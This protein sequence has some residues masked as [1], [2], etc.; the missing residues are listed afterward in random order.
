MMVMD[1][2]NDDDDKECSNAS[3]MVCDKGG[4]HNR[5]EGK[6][7]RING[8]YACTLATATT[9][10]VM[11]RRS[12]NRQRRCKEMQRDNQ[13]AQTERRG[14]GW[15]CATPV[16][17]K[18]DTRRRHAKTGNA[19]T[20]WHTRGKWE[21]RHQQTTGNGASIDQG[22]AFRGGGRV[23][24]MRGG[25]INV[26]TSRQRRDDHGGGK[27]DKEWESFKGLREADRA[28]RNMVADDIIGALGMENKMI[29]VTI[30][31]GAV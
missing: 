22:C 27:S 20:S 2:N 8:N 5:D 30:D 9:Q 4:N 23:E 13:L 28:G 3:S 12:V 16:Q 26:T 10:P 31:K 17:Q 19:T 25:G 6:D 15:T 24:R 7:L 18:G 11:R 1:I 14:Q 21:E 29:E